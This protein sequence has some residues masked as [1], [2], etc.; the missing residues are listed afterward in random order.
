MLERGKT[1]GRSDDNEETIAKRLTTFNEQTKPVVEF[2]EKAG[3][4]MRIDAN[5]EIQAIAKD[6]EGHMDSLGIFPK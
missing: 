1:S 3:K 4:V 2:Y 6:V 5:R